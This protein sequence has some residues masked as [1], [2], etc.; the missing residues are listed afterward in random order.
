MDRLQKN[1]EL[2]LLDKA[3]NK[4]LSLITHEL[5][6]PLNTIIVTSEIISTKM[7]STA[8]EH[9]ELSKNLL[10]QSQNLLEL[11]NDIL[12]LT[13]IHSGKMEFYIQ[14]G[15]P[16]A[17]LETQKSLFFDFAKDR[18]VQIEIVQP[19]EPLD[20][21]FDDIHL[22]QIFSNLFSNAIKFNIPFGKVT[23]E[24]HDRGD[25]IEISFKDTGIGIAP[26]MLESIFNEFE[27]IER[28]SHHHKGTGLGL[29]IARSLAKGMGG[30]ILLKSTLT[31]GSTF[32]AILPRTQVLSL[33]VY[34]HRCADSDVIFFNDES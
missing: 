25:F 23:V 32:S 7:Y 19:K 12:D 16:F 26:D 10:L 6:T 22:K 9:D 5:R 11:V 13:K 18:K 3:K 27:T 21:Y 1:H 20:C 17:L 31:K 14:Q 4:F 34:R 2:E 15:D 8:Q 29:S 33:D 24:G 28:I 30:E